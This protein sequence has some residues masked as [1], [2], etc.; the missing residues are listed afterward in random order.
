MSRNAI[1][2][3]TAWVSFA[4]SAAPQCPQL[5][6]PIKAEYL[7][8]VKE[9]DA[10]RQTHLVLW[11][12]ADRVAH[13][14]PD[15][16]ITEGWEQVH[17]LIKPTRYFDADQRA[18]EYQPGEHV[19]GKSEHDWSLRYQLLP[20]R[21]LSQLTHT[22]EQAGECANL[23]SEH[24][25]S[26]DKALEVDWMPALQLVQAYHLKQKTHT[27]SWQLVSWSQDAAQI[28]AFFTSRDGY[29]STD[30]ADIG[31]NH[32][33][34]F[35]TKMVNLGFIEHAATGFYDADGHA[36]QGGHQH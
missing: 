5:D 35:L 25:V 29:N 6:Q 15:T 1:L 16:Q 28:N 8:T 12:Q 19:H 33:D 24:R 2:L 21:L 23:A 4:V 30:F 7:V 22:G 20:Q 32:T 14:Y 27:E 13:Q 31:D 17:G 3:L 18:I 26:S 11:R 10:V 34:P 36:I 9:G